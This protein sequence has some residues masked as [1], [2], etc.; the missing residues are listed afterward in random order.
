MKYKIFWT[1]L[2]VLCILY[3]I[4]VFMAGSGTG[5]FIVWIALGILCAAF[6]VFSGRGRWKK[7]PKALRTVLIVILVF[8]LGLFVFVEALILTG[9]KETAKKDLDVII[10]LGAQVYES[11]PS[12]VLQ[13]RLDKAY[14]Y[15]DENPG[16]V[17]I[18]T[19]GKGPNEPFSEAEGMHRYLVSRG[20]SESR[21][22][23]EDQADNTKENI[24]FSMQLFDAENESAGII[25]NN[26]HMYRALRL[27]KKAGLTGVCGIPAPSTPLY[28]PNNMLREFFGVVLSYIAGYI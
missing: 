14:E 22:L 28:L 21:I 17:C 27:A 9:F 2:A 4:L 13:Y 20:I 18:V 15:L 23:P 25:S 3:G 5:F 7:L 10:V 26:F 24:S 11:G 16:T 12:A 8:L 1:I 6:A 19:G